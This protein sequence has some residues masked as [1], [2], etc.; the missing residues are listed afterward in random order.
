M[1]LQSPQ[2][3]LSV[4]NFQAQPNDYD[5]SGYTASQLQDLLTRASAVADSMMGRSFLP[6]EVTEVFTGDGTNVLSLDILGPIIYVKSVELVL[7]GFAP[8][9]LPIGELFVDYQRGNIRSYSTL[10]WRSLGVSSVFPKNNLPIVVNYAYGKGYP[11]PAPA[12]TI[13]AGPQGGTLTPGAQYD[14][15]ITSRT[16][17]GES[18]PAPTQTFTVGSSGSLAALITPQP[19]A[20]LCRVYVAPHGQPLNLVAESPATNYANSTMT[21]SITSLT[22]AAYLLTQPVPTS[23]TSAWPLEN[24]FIE[25][26]RLI[27]L[28]TL[29]EQNNLANRGIYV[30]DSGKKRISWVSTEGR[31]GK[32]TPTMMDQARAL[33]APYHFAGIF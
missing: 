15:A 29:F 33:L 17:S 13:E 23:D 31:S 8:F 22:P 1:Y 6:Q 19:G 3:Y 28:S 5:L 9:Q 2:T 16:Q 30:Q 12:F 20:M 18:L 7:P 27:A 25:A 11:I 4:A 26:T 10:I 21:V 14:V 32:G 24:A